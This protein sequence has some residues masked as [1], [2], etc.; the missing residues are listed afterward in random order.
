MIFTNRFY[1]LHLNKYEK[2]I[3]RKF[4]RNKWKMKNGKARLDFSYTFSWILKWK[5][6]RD[7]IN[8][9]YAYAV[10]AYLYDNP[11]V[12]YIDQNKMFINSLS[13]NKGI[14]KRTKIY[15]DAGANGN[16]YVRGY[17]SRLQVQIIERGLKKVVRK[18]KR[19]S[20]GMTKYEKVKMVH[21]YLIDNCRYDVE[22][23]N[24]NMF[25]I[26]GALIDGVC[27]CAGYAKAL[28]YI[29][30]AM[31]IKCICVI[32][33]GGDILERP[34]GHAWNYVKLDGK[35]YAIDV[36]WDDPI[37]EQTEKHRYEYFLMGSKQ[38]TKDH[39]PT[40]AYDY[41]ELAGDGRDKVCYKL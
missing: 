25:N 15:M 37:G 9:Y 1:Y 4:E 22:F 28:K 11:D 8:Q 30:N 13:K 34:E 35:W 16:Y 14:M 19:K 40:E 33:R 32:G 38:I 23:A 2:K 12:F 36:T 20:H 39:L 41:P 17:K 21:D 10:R 24:P 18:L 27:V 31:N 5:N 6:G 29:L 3:Y 26:Y 7:K